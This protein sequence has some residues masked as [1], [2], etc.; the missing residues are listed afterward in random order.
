[1]QKN[2]PLCLPTTPAT[3][4]PVIPG[5][6]CPTR[7]DYLTC[8]LAQLMEP[9]A[10]GLEEIHMPRVTRLTLNLIALQNNE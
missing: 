9:M 7:V 6:V 10:L 8:Q 4:V 2:K 5:V 1:M 3:A